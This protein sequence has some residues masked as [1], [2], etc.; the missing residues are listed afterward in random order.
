METKNL[1]AGVWHF[2]GL[3]TGNHNFQVRAING[4]GKIDPT[5]ASV[6][7]LIHDWVESASR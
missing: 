2:N 1:L 5:P 7:W 3:G 6:N 4:A